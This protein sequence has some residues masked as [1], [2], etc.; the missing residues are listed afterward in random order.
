M[1][2]LIAD[3]MDSNAGSLKNLGEKVGVNFEA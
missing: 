2:I 1:L 3:A